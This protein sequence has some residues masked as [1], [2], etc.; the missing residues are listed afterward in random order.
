LSGQSLL[1]SVGNFFGGTL[2]KEKSTQ[3]IIPFLV[4]G[5][6]TGKIKNVLYRAQ[7]KE[8]VGSLFCLKSTP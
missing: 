8:S 1:I 5:T 6:G 7:Q 2:L 4:N 3:G